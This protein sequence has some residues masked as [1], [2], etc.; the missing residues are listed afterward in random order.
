MDM[1]QKLDYSKLTPIELKAIAISYQNM[2]KDEGEAFNS[3]FPYMTSAIEVLAEQLFDYP[4]DNI[5]ELKTLHDELLAANK[6]LLQLAPNPPSFNPEEIAATLTND[7]IIDG[8]LKNSIVISLVET[9]TYFQKV[10]ADRIND[11]ENG[12]LKGVN[13]GS[14]N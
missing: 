2:K 4:A 10:V 7:E 8:L 13:N 3:S 11:I 5:E 14:I 1:N 6:H 9:F 12:V